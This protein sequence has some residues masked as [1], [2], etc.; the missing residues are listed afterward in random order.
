MRADHRG[1]SMY[2]DELLAAER[3]AECYPEFAAGDSAGCRFR[4]P[5]M[6]GTRLRGAGRRWMRGRSPGRYQRY[7]QLLQEYKQDGGIGMNKIVEGWRHPYWRAD[8]AAMGDG[9]AHAGKK[10][11]G[12][13]ACGCDDGTFV[14]NISS[15]RK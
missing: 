8:F 2:E 6:T 15:D 1:F 12:I 5:C 7:V 11:A 14:P 4:L 3:V 13:C 10:A 9:G